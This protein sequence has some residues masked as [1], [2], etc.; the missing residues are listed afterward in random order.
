MKNQTNANSTTVPLKDCWELVNKARPQMAEQIYLLAK[1]LSGARRR[2]LNSIGRWLDGS[3]NYEALLERPDVLCFCLPWLKA[4]LSKPKQTPLTE[5]EMATAIRQGFCRFEHSAPLPRNWTPFL[6]P[7]IT[8][9]VW[10]AMLTFGSVWILPKLISMFH[11][12]GIKLPHATEFVLGVGSWLAT[13]WI[14]FFVVLL[15]PIV[16]FWVF[17]RISQRDRVY[18]L[19]W[20]DR[21]FSRFRFQLSVWASHVASLLSAGVDDLEAIQIAGRCSANSRLKDSCRDFTKGTQGD[22]LDRTKYPLINNSVS[23]NN[24]AAKIAIL[25]EIGRY[26]RSLGNVVENWWLSLLSKA[27]I[28]FICITVGIVVVSLYLPLTSI[29]GGLS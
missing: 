21:R 4:I 29:V 20:V 13:N 24:R 22:L 8:F 5:E 18:S 1:T 15:L 12:L 11:E 6:Y 28:V 9:F 16:L 3:Q 26:Y 2:Q 19:S 17:L 7:T 14:P 25:E 23:L 10:L 27:M